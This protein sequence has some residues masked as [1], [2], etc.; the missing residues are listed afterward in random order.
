VFLEK[1]KSERIQLLTKNNKIN[2]DFME[3]FIEDLESE[4]IAKLETYLSKVKGS[5]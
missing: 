4:R 3:K 1:I 2:F 5:K